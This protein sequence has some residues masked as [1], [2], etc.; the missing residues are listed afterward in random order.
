MLSHLPD[1]ALDL[2]TADR[3]IF[4]SDPAS[5]FNSRIQRDFYS[6]QRIR[7]SDTA[8]RFTPNNLE[9]T[10]LQR[11]ILSTGRKASQTIIGRY[12]R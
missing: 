10:Q 4:R 8:E 11:P 9:M 3:E 5:D 1:M 12:L 2:V 7:T 6:L